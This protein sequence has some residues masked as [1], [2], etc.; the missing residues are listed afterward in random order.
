MLTIDGEPTNP[1]AWKCKPVANLAAADVGWSDKNF[2]DS[3]WGAGKVSYFI[4][5]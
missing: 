2:D 4:V 5:D 3:S 1:T